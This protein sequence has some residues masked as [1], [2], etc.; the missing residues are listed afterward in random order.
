M[1]GFKLNNKKKVHTSLR[2]K[3]GCQHRVSKPQIHK[4][5]HR[6]GKGGGNNA[7]F[8]TGNCYKLDM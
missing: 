7:G 8:V 3:L 5:I 6:C 2:H 4:A 1:H